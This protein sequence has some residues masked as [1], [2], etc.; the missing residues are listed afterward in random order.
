MQHNHCFLQINCFDAL[1]ICKV[2][3][4]MSW[5]EATEWIIIIRGNKVKG[6]SFKQ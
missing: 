4:N 6:L 2:V 5:I 1:L 3:I